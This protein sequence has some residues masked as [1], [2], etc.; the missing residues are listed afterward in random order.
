MKIAQMHSVVFRGDAVSNVM[1][2]LDQVHRD[3]KWESYLIAD[4]FS[5]IN[6]VPLLASSDY[7]HTP[8]IQSFVYLLSR[9]LRLENKIK[10]LKI[11]FNSKK[12]YKPGLA[13]SII[14]SSDIRIWHFGA[15]YNLFKYFHEGDILFYHGVTYPYLSY[16][17][18]L[19]IYSKNMLQAILDMKPFV[20]VQSNFIK[21]SLIDLGFKE[22][23]V[24]VLP[25]FHK[26][27]LPYKKRNPKEPKLIAWGRYA[28]NKAIPELVKAC[29]E[30]KLNIRIFG[31]NT[32]TKEFVDQYKEALA[33]NTEG[34]AKLS[35]KVDDFEAEL[36]NANIY[37][38]NSYHEGFN[39]PLIEAE[40]HSMP[41]LARRGTAMDEL[42]K[43]GYNGFL[44]D[45]ISEIPDLVNRIMKDYDRFSR[46]AYEHSKN[47]TYER[48]K[49]RY[50]N[51]IDE[52]KRY[53]NIKK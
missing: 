9:F 23:S 20:I 53:K 34:Y 13:K 52:Y 37:I 17:P 42:V 48:F 50:L 10:Y 33:N 51:I 39:M 44:F 18:E 2:A 38:C 36:E 31:D 49:E 21:Q 7:D 12:K 6:D 16:F 14:E 27:N 4:L 28:L 45:D 5:E 19:N 15:F 43:D 22:E 26:Y 41:V 35:G 11:Y 46:N 29:N 8:F 25:L 1:R 32:Q 24:Y 30:Y 47:F 40:A 3:K